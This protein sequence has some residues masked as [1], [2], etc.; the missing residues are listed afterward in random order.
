M[1]LQ[2]LE[3]TLKARE[4]PPFRVRQV[5]SWIARGAD[6]YEEMTDLPASL[7][8]ALA[9]ELPF[10]SLTLRRE[11]R[12]RDGTVK[13]LFSTA[14]GHPLEAVM[15]RYG[16]LGDA[17]Q[18]RDEVVAGHGQAGQLEAVVV[19]GAEPG[20]GRGGADGPRRRYGTR[21]AAELL[22]RRVRRRNSCVGAA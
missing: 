13:A 20:D 22:R 8:S 10:S 18:E 5:W 9:R 3:K 14:D 2:L 21:R 12:A 6:S 7:R 17:A 19:P 1:D 4:E 16:P 11:L 15:M